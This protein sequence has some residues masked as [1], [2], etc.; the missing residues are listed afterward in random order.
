[1]PHLAVALLCRSRRL[2]RAQD[3]PSKRSRSSSRSSRLGG[4]D[5]AGRWL[6]DSDGTDTTN[7]ANGAPKDPATVQAM[8]Q[9][10]MEAAVIGLDDF[11]VY[12]KTETKWWTDQIRPQASNRSES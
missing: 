9:G 6:C 7:A 12:V 3:F 8:M 4:R 2:A 10:R 1:M 5:R 11:T